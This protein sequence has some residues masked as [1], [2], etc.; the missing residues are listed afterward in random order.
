MTVL[1]FWFT[2]VPM[3][4]FIRK[5]DIRMSVI[6]LYGVLF[7]AGI[8]GLVNVAV[9]IGT[10]AGFASLLLQLSA[11]LTVLAAVFLFKESLSKKKATGIIAAFVGFSVVVLFRS[12]SVP[13]GGVIL[14]F[15]AAAFWTMCNMIIR[16]TEP[17]N[18]VSFIVWSSIFVPIPIILAALGRQVVIDGHVAWV[19]I[20]HMPTVK[21]WV[22]ILF[23]SFV[24]T[25]VGYSIWTL[26]ITR[27]GLANVAPYSLLVPI[28]GLF[29]GWVIYNETL[30][31]A[32][33]AGSL[34]VIFGLIL[35]SI[36]QIQIKS[37]CSAIVDDAASQ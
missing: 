25:L 21:A 26:A 17:D 4:F 28:S 37:T 1:R 29:F 8:W 9:S 24:T 34:L 33:F 2:A 13:I 35:L 16:V 22:S 18:V 36:G 32:E 11:F 23:Q 20:L 7:G 27:Y 3:I 5:P 14:V 6:A 19:Y 15:A 12:G 30:S 31:L 10:P